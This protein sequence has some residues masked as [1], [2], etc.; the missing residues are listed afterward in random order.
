MITWLQNFFMKHNKFLFGGLLVVIIVTFVLT[1]GPQSFFG[2]GGGVQRK[3]INF[4]GYDLTSQA[5]L[6][7]IA[8]NAE[9][10]A[11]LHPELQIRGEQVMDYGYMRIAALGIA[12]QIGV[13][14]ATEEGLGGFVET[15]EIFRN[16]QT[17]QFS[18]QA[19]QNLL[20]AMQANGRFTREAIAR[21]LQEDYRIRQVREALGGPDYSLPFEH[22]QDFLASRTQYTIAVARF[23]FATFQPEIDLTEEALRQYYNENPA[24]YEVPETLSVKA[25]FFEA[26]AYL[27]ELEAPEEATLQ[28]YFQTNRD[29]YTPETGDRT[30]SETDPE[31]PP[32]VSLED[33]REAVLADWKLEEARRLAARKGEQFSIQLWQNSVAQGSETYQKM[34]EDYKVRTRDLPAFPRENPPSVEGVSRE[35]LSSIW[36]YARNP[37]R[38]F[39]DVSRNAEGAVLLVR[40]DLQ[41]A[42]MPEFEAVREEVEADLQAT[43]KRRLFAEKGEELRDTIASRIPA[44]SFTEVAA[45]LG[46]EVESLD[47]FEGNS[48][49]EPLRIPTLWD[50]ARFLPE[51]GVSPM[52]LQDGEGVLACVLEKSQPEMDPDSEEFQ[53]FVARRSGNLSQAMGWARLREI[54]DTSLNSVLGPTALN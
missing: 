18:A 21:V 16:P 10:S 2:S 9:I 37:N 50:Q 53:Q 23:D 39:S 1:I 45:E 20:R 30:E 15:L 31:S 8:R 13:P 49:P 25:L 42:F 19:Y 35:A 29:R 27:D 48:V 54:S 11:I 51:G 44:E 14:P 22:E 33:V 28:A 12:E 26:D 40:Q 46:L 3:S 5:D 17:G 38:Y 4:Y 24:R 36:V 43:E 7:A 47:P 34:L 6:Q 32:E 52:V 41:E